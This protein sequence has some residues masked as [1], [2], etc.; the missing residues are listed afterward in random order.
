[1]TILPITTAQLFIAALCWI[2]LVVHMTRL[3]GGGRWWDFTALCLFVLGMV[4]TM[5]LAE[6]ML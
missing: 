2:V 3:R 1:M 4:L 5:D 6:K